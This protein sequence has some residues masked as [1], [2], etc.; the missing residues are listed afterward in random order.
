MNKN[1]SKEELESLIK[2]S[3]SIV[4]VFTKLKL[5][6][7]DSSNHYRIF[8]ELVQKFNIDC[9][10]FTRG[11]KVNR[12]Y[13]AKR[14]ISEYLENKFPIQS[15]KLKKRLLAENILEHKCSVCNNDTWMN[16]PIPIELDH[17]DG[18]SSN[19]NL[20][21][22]RLLCPNCHAQ[23]DNYCG[24]NIKKGTKNQKQFIK[25]PKEIKEKKPYIRSKK[26][27]LS[28]DEIY[29]IFISNNKNYTHTGKDLGIS[30]NAVR[31][32]IKNIVGGNSR[33]RTDTD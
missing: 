27:F 12:T 21:N 8:R 6:N 1:I 2:E 10:H 3:N 7:L 22:L 26:C 17:I 19:N 15:N 9:S 32:R 24:K 33:T 18:N 5:S 20:S 30:D 16:S 31:K 13:V 29:S 11:S 28:D 25:P 14:E 23:T 4:E